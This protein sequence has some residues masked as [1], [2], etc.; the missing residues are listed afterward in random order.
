MACVEKAKPLGKVE[1][2]IIAE[3]LVTWQDEIIKKKSKKKKKANSAKIAGLT[4]IIA[5]LLHMD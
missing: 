3:N 4:F 1:V 5:Y 2:K